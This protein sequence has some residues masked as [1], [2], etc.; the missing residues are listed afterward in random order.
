MANRATWQTKFVK[1]PYYMKHDNNRIVCEGIN[2][3]ATTHIVFGNPA[4][5]E[6]YMHKHCNEI[7]GCRKCPLHDLLDRKNG[8]AD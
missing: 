3:D 2:K 6:V 5:R 4:I 7:G 8:D 1:C